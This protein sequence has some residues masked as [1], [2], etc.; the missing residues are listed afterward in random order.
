[1]WW[2]QALGYAVEQNVP[3]FDDQYLIPYIR[4]GLD[5]H[6]N[7]ERNPDRIKFQK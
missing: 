5:C 4:N 6:N 7:G 3:L 2:A 1:M